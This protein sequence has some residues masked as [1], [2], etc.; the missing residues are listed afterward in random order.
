MAIQ[1]YSFNTIIIIITVIVSFYVDNKPEL[2][3]RFMLN[4]Y[5]IVKDKE[6]FRFITSGFIHGGWMHLFFNM[7]TLY[8]FGNMLEGIFNYQLGSNGSYYYV[9]FYLAAIVVADI[10]TFIKHKNNPGYNALGASGGTSAVVLSYIMFD[11]LVP[12]RP[13]LLP[14]P[15]PGFIFAALYMAYSYY[16][17]KNDKMDGIG[18]DAHFFGALFGVIVSVGIQPNVIGNFFTQ[19]A[20]WS[21][22]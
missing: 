4:P 1:E 18:H 16:M 9:L 2:K 13:I 11:P 12:L 21:I 7:F 20:S 8:L 3:Y 6:Y 15:I 14:I 22:F 19:L 17:A 10:P 5:R